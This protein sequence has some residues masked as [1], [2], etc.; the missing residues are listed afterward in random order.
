METVL[1][2]E[3]QFTHNQQPLRESV[4]ASI[5]RYLTHLGDQNVNNLYDMVLAEVEE[6][7]LRALLK[8]TR[9]NQSKTA[10]MLGLS[11]GTLR[12]K[13]KMYDLS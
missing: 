6:P 12:K 2:K 1:A 13:L 8:H 7:L 11:R 10:R 5:E 9:G 3:Q 4:E